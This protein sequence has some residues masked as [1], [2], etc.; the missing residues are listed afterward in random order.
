M[1]AISPEGARLTVPPVP[2]AILRWAR[3][4]HGILYC[5]FDPT[6][7]DAWGR[8]IGASGSV[9]RQWCRSAGFRPKASLDFA[10]VLRA[11]VLSQGRRWEIYNLLNVVDD[12]TM[13]KLFARAGM[14]ELAS[15]PEPPVTSVYL[16]EQQFVRS[17]QALPA[18]AALLEADAADERGGVDD[19]PS[20]AFSSPR[21]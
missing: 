21:S 19:P 18:I 6:T 4:V 10:R 14:P 16:A 9:I 15:R 13:R 17:P 12:R 2:H 20:V 1:R 8:V 5:S 7:I 3:A 11:V